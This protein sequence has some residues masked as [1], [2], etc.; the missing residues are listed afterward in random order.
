[1][2]I[3]TVIKPDDTQP[4]PRV[5]AAQARLE[6]S[7]TVLWVAV[8]MVGL[9]AL[10]SLA[11]NILLVTRLLA[12][13]NGI[14]DTLA[15]ASRSLDNL[16][17]QGLSFDFP[18]SQTVSFEGDVPIK[19]DISF[20]VKGNFPVDT[21]INA[22]IDLGSLGTQ[23]ISVPVKTTVPVD[24]TVPVHVEQTVRV[25]TQVPVRLIVPIRLNPNEPPLKDWLTQLR[26]AL[27]NIRKT[28]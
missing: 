13:R 17:W 20:P 11:V 21:T 6:R 23:T 3:G 4:I 8:V 18:I 27:E 12:I 5:A 22:T 25:K 9:M 26:E 7:V 14:A 16:A 2:S 24:V 1:M 28:L 10:V 15:G 19:Q